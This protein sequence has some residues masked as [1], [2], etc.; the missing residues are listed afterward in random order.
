MRKTLLLSLALLG[1]GLPTTL[2]LLLVLL[3]PTPAAKWFG[4]R[5]IIESVERD[6]FGN[7]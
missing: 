3:Q 2:K 5:A 1:L 6:T 7:Q 4:R